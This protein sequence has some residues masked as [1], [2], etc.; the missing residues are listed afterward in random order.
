M[1]PINVVRKEGWLQD[2]RVWLL[3]VQCGCQIIISVPAY[4]LMKSH[5]NQV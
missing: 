2:R 1:M 3:Q 5:G 4:P